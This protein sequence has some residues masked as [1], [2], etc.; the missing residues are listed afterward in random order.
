MFVPPTTLPKESV[1]GLEELRIVQGAKGWMKN[2]SNVACKFIEDLAQMCGRTLA[3]LG[4]I[5][6]VDQA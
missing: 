6:C 1:D 3:I 5:Q 2:V 4:R